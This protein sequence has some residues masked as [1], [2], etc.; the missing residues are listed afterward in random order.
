MGWVDMMAMLGMGEELK[1]WK[2]E[3]SR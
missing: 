1:G 3:P 2:I